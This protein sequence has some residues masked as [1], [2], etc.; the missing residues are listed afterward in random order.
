[1]KTDTPVRNSVSRFFGNDLACTYITNN[2][3]K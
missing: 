1:M 3:N 2:A